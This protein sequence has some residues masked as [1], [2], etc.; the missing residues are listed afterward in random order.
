[1]ND[2]MYQKPYM[3]VASLG[4]EMVRNGRHKMLCFICI[5]LD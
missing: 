4:P 3:Y 1:M 5:L 2:K